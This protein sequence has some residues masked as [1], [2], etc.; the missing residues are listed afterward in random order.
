MLSLSRRRAQTAVG[1]ALPPGTLPVACGLMVYGVTAYGFLVI[2][3]RALGP[4][5][6][7]GVS[8]L[9][10]LTFL[11]AIG[12]FAPLEQEVAR[13]MADRRARGT[14]QTLLVRRSAVMG[15]AVL[16]ALLVGLAVSTP[17]VIGAIFD[18]QVSL[19]L[20]LGLGLGAYY[21]MHLARGVLSGRKRLATYG[22][23]LAAEGV[24]R[25]LACALLA[26][27]GVRSA[28]AYG[29]VLAVSPLVAVVMVALSA[30]GGVTVDAGGEAP[31]RD[32]WT[33]YGHLMVGA[34]ASQLLVNGPAVAVKALATPGEQ[35]LAGRLLAG[36]IVTRIPLFLFAAVQ[37]ALLPNLATLAAEG[38][39][40]EF[41]AALLRLVILVAG[42]SSLTVLATFLVGPPA[43]RLLF[44]ADFSLGRGV[45]TGL[46]FGNA[47]FLVAL[48]CAQALIALRRH[49]VVGVGWLAGFAVFLMT[50]LLHQ[51]LAARV[52]LA[53]VAGSLVALLS[54]SVPLLRRRPPLPPG[55]DRTE[56]IGSDVVSPVFDIPG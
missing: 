49:A 9:W 30:R 24:I 2:A 7:A 16:V 25:L 5:R 18:D 48:L 4:Q 45:L 27:T 51:A 1:R 29:L 15:G 39:E 41:R 33:S 11:G 28:G 6:Y 46:A 53:F 20:S 12:F 38:R 35:V 36:L 55:G 37:A 10:A 31:W 8:V 26:V 22:V 32:L 42:L 3:G 13:S 50:S 21:V 56:V 47:L 43:L 44:G 54:L 40:K 19:A 17:F 14:G 34:V 52:V 23:L